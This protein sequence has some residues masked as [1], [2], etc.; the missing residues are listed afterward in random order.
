MNQEQLKRFPIVKVGET[1]I[2]TEDVLAVEE[3]L[4]MRLAGETIATTMRTPGNDHLLAKGFFFSEGFIHELSQVGRVYHCGRLGTP[5]YGNVIEVL[6]APGQLLDFEEPDRV[7]RGTLIS[8]ACGGCGRTQIDDLIE[9]CQPFQEFQTLEGNQITR[10][11]QVLTQNQSL[12]ERT[13][14]VHAVAAFEKGGALVGCFE[15]V[16]RHNATD[17]VVGKMFEEGVIG[18]VSVLVVS[19]RVSF[20]II[21]KAAMARISSVIGISAPTSLAVDLAQALKMT[22]VGFARGNRWN[23]YTG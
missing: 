14:G 10:C 7:K 23:Q 1:R 5:E 8:S 18:K 4:E 11:L 13:G 22:L 3:P 21:Q 17:K 12:F 9:R 16:G 15:D 6:P 20:E 2:S 19:G